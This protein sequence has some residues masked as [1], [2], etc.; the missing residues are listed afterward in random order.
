MTSQSLACHAWAENA[1]FC[2][3]WRYW[4]AKA[5]AMQ[6]DDNSPETVEAVGRWDRSID[7]WG[8]LLDLMAK[9]DPSAMD[10]AVRW[11][12]EHRFSSICN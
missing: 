9:H 8:T 3:E 1:A 12:L 2:A 5:Y 4:L 7:C 10:R 11:G 6:L